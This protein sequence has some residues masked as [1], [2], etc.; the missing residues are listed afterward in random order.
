MRESIAV[1][2]YN[3]CHVE[4]IKITIIATIIYIY[5]SLSTNFRKL[6]TNFLKI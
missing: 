1:L 2:E 4:Q 6:Q 3:I 5:V